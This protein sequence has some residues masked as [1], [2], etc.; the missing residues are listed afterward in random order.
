MNQTIIFTKEK[1]TFQNINLD[2]VFPKKEK[3]IKITKLALFKKNKSNSAT[4]IPCEWQNQ[5]FTTYLWNKFNISTVKSKDNSIITLIKSISEEHDCNFFDC[6]V[7]PKK[8]KPIKILNL[9]PR[10][11][12]CFSSLSMFILNKIQHE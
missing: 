8:E 4:K 2:H 1:E 12:W 5:P 3:L 7:F 9:T 11:P 10:F 6:N